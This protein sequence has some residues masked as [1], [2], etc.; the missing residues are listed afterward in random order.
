MS[1]IHPIVEEY[2]LGYARL[3]AFLNIDSSFTVIRRFDYLHLRLLLEKQAHLGELERR[4]IK[5]DDKEMVQLYASSCKQDGN[6]Q[7]RRL[8]EEVQLKIHDYDNS[9]LKYRRIL[10][11]SDAKKQHLNSIKNWINRNRPIVRSESDW[12]LHLLSSDN[13]IALKASDSG[14]TGLENLLDRVLKKWP[15]FFSKVVFSIERRENSF[16][17]ILTSCHRVR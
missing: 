10:Q 8:I 17:L 16:L 4:L 3:A 15:R 9:V 1:L 13:F 12:V 7:R 2:R 5:C 6:V 11:L 14:E